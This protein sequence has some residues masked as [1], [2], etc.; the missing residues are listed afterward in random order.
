MRD[1][2]SGAGRGVWWGVVKWWGVVRWG[3]MRCGEVVTEGRSDALWLP[4]CK[5]MWCMDTLLAMSEDGLKMVEFQNIG[6]TAVPQYV[7][8]HEPA[9]ASL[10]T[11]DC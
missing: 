1:H 5:P 9:I 8:R 4:S 6:I 11:E 2:S 10:A 7:E 3:V